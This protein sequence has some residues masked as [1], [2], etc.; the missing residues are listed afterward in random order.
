MPPRIQAL[1][2]QLLPAA[3]PI[4]K[5]GI[6][7]LRQCLRL[8]SESIQHHTRQRRS[9]WMWFENQGRNF[10][11]PLPG[12]TNYLGAYDSRGRLKRLT[13]STVQ[14]GS[15]GSQQATEGLSTSDE[16]LPQETS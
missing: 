16:P 10:L 12:S 5:N 7:G 14:D 1:P 13:G 9:M 6:S 3:R 8:F 15:D 11:N 4:C 2:Q